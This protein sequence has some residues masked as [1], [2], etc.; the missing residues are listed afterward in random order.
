LFA[1][2]GQPF[3]TSRRCGVENSIAEDSVINDSVIRDRAFVD[4]VRR[5]WPDVARDL[6][7]RQTR[8]PWAVLVSEAMAQQTQVTRV[9]PAWH[10]FL[11]R[12]P[13]PAAVASASPGEVVE[14]WDGL[15]YNRRAIMLHRCAVEIVER[16]GGTIPSRLEDL[17]AL[18]GVGP[19]T[20][21]AVLVFAFE[22]DV[23][24]VDTNVGRVLARVGGSRLNNTDAQAQ[25]DRLVPDGNGWEWN[26][27]LLDFGATVC[28]KRQPNCDACP[29]R[30][31]CAWR[32]KGPDP[33]VD[34]AGVTARQSR[35]DG[36]DRQGRGR[37]V[38]ALRQGP[39]E[40][41]LVATVM[42]WGDDSARASRV[43]ATLVDDGLVVLNEQVARLP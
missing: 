36:S 13:S 18:P 27:A 21:R 23:A 35:F 42:G 2:C 28:V 17:L 10:R 31:V 11:D 20:A 34:S 9:I 32:G 8:D 14:L 15:G 26:Q 33:V 30:A 19:Y 7:W 37:L 3:E 25:A 5:W 1:P 38:S 12:F 39:V 43:F 24:V 22:Q 29:V 40:L 4:R 41:E 6:P 16:H